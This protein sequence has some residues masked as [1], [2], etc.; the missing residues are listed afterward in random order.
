MCASGAPATCRLS[1]SYAWT[2]SVRQQPH[3]IHHSALHHGARARASLASQLIELRQRLLLDLLLPK[4]APTADHCAKSTCFRV[5]ATIYLTCNHGLQRAACMPASPCRCLSSSVTPATG[6]KA[7]LACTDGGRRQG[8]RSLNL[9]AKEHNYTEA[10][11]QSTFLQQQGS[12]A[13]VD[14]LT[15]SS[16]RT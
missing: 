9:R 5:H 10:K 13:L 15:S 3:H 4:H 8:N 6:P 16:G 11:S 7:E 2:Q 14:H 12:A 1:S